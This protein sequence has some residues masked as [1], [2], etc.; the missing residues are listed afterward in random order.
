MHR[1]RQARAA[2]PA[3][4]LHRDV[5]LEQWERVNP[6]PPKFNRAWRRLLGLPGHLLRPPQACRGRC[7]FTLEHF[8]DD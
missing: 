5:S 1:H 7:P 8:T 4:V 2:V 6:D 3:A